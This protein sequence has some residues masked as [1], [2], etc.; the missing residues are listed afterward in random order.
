MPMRLM[1]VLVY[2][3]TDHPPL[4]EGDDQVAM[5]IQ[6]FVIPIKLTKLHSAAEIGILGYLK[7]AT[8]YE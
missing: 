2:I 4:Y 1:L 8:Y 7:K 6:T 5:A 3:I